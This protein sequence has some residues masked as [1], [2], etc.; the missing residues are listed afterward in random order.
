ML[1]FEVKVE[2]FFKLDVVK[3]I[4][5]KEENECNVFIMD[6][7]DIIKVIEVDEKK[8]LDK[9]KEYIENKMKEL[10]DVM[11]FDIFVEFE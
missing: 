8:I 10:D 7:G 2:Y 11:K 3:I 1:E 9:K 5:I 4:I 6:E